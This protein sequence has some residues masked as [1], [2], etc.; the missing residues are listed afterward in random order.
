[1]GQENSVVEFIDASDEEKKQVQ[2]RRGIF[3]EDYAI[4]AKSNETCSL[5]NCDCIPNRKKEEAQ[6]DVKICSVCNNDI[7][8]FR[9]N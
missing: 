9:K 8:N 1:M 3:V 6:K 7:K 4:N 2:K 5:P